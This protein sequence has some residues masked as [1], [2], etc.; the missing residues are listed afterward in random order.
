MAQSRTQ[1]LQDSVHGLMEFH[2][3]ETSVVEVLRA[4]ELQRLR[5]IRQLGLAHLVFPGAEHS[6]LVHVLGSAY[7]AVRFAR[8]LRETT[9][10]FLAEPLRPFE[11]EVRDFAIAAL[12]HDL[13]HGPL[14][15]VW[16]REVIGEPFAREQWRKSLGLPDDPAFEG[17]RWHELVGQAL[18]AWPEGEL[19][20]LLEQRETGST[21]R[22]RLLLLGEYYVPYLPRLLSS[23]IDVDRCDFIMRD[24]L[25]TGVAYGR[26]D[27]SWLISTAT[28][29]QTDSR[30]LVVAFDARK[31]PSVV[32]QLLVARRSMYQTVYHHRTVRSAE[33]MIGLLFRRLRDIFKSEG[34]RSEL[35]FS[36]SHMFEALRKA[37]NG[38]VLEPQDILQLDDYALWVFIR[39]VADSS[40]DR[41]LSDLAKRII[42][43]DLFKLVPIP[44]ER[45]K[46]FLMGRE[47]HDRIHEAVKPYCAGE[48]HYYVHI[49]HATFGML[50]GKKNATA[51]FS[52]PGNGGLPRAVPIQDHPRLRVHPLEA[53]STVRL[54][55]PREAVQAVALAVGAS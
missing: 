1:R 30:E 39:E 12:C 14:S 37:V 43:R 47:A 28:V 7:L 5:R 29:A 22:I 24:A 6:R 46:E 19:H 38:G 26:F 33:G 52:E 32:E 8:H 50:S 54:Y 3:M 45:L 23:D 34:T 15:H 53:S 18:L 42:S 17:L 40:K 51:Y 55:V 10:D 21:T 41:T 2:G 27:L 35:L 4:A 44:E 48:P 9:R 11:S 31:S 16:E 13:G 25:Q 20:Q 36:N 49:D